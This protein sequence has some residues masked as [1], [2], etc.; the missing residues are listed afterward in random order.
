ME[1]ICVF[2]ITDTEL[3]NR[4]DEDILN[5]SSDA[6]TCCLKTN[7]VDEENCKVSSKN[8]LWQYIVFFCPDI[9]N[10]FC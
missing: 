4:G 1:E 10:V 7:N 3:E 9:M 6:Q 8:K 5:I 2:L